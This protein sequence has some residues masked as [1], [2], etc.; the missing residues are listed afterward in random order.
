[1]YYHTTYQQE[2]WPNKGIE[3]QVNNSHVGEGNY[4]EFK[5]GGS[6]YSYRN[7]YR[8][9]IPDNTWYEIHIKVED[10]HVQIWINGQQTVDF[11]APKRQQGHGT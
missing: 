6:L 5:K 7:I 3:A 11:I 1:M 10:R 9:F 2:G 4:V 8:R